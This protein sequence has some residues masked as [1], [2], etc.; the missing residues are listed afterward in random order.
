MTHRFE[1]NQRLADCETIKDFGGFFIGLWLQEKKDVQYFTF[2]TFHDVIKKRLLSDKAVWSNP[3]GVGQS[4]MKRRR[5][6]I[7]VIDQQY[8]DALEIIELFHTQQLD[9]QR[10]W[11]A[12]LKTTDDVLKAFEALQELEMETIRDH[13]D[14]LQSRTYMNV[15]QTIANADDFSEHDLKR[16]QNML[17]TAPIRSIEFNGGTAEKR[18][19]QKVAFDESNKIPIMLEAGEQEWVTLPYKKSSHDTMPVFYKQDEAE[20]K[21]RN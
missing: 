11:E 5:Q 16:F 21:K 10:L 15:E 17:A 13:K 19:E 9:D 14:A 4:K 18:A 1:Y 12:Q 20:E 6:F 3:K 2:K 8:D 7:S